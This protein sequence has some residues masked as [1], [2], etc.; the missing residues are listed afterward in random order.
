M[1]LFEQLAHSQEVRGMLLEPLARLVALASQVGVP[2]G[3]G[4]FRR[5]TYAQI[6]RLG[7]PTQA[8]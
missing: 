3:L 6:E 2:G 5:D 7:L 4:A 1:V 8:R